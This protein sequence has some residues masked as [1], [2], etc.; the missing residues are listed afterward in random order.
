MLKKQRRRRWLSGLLAAVM[1]L[2]LLPVSAFAA[3]TEPTGDSLQWVEEKVTEL[4]EGITP[5]YQSGGWYP[6]GEGNSDLYYNVYIRYIGGAKPI[7]DALVFVVPGDNANE[8]NCAIPDFTSLPEYWSKV[9]PSQI[10][11]GDGVTGI[12]NNAF[13]GMD[14]VD[15]VTF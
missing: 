12:G 2:S 4:N 7:T 1:V 8:N 10:F 11:I 5:P 6:F 15:L 9:S 3:A 14:T 13:V